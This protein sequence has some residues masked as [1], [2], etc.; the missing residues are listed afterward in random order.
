MD[1]T[2]DA[3]LDLMA[4]YL[5][6]KHTPVPLMVAAL[7]ST[8]ALLESITDESDIK[9]KDVLTIIDRQLSTSADDKVIKDELNRQ[10]VLISAK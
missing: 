8:H 1:Y 10:Q 9:T 7:L 3:V 5:R 2:Q 4:Q 6:S